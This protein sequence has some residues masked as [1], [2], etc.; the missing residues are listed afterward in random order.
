MME[1][2]IELINGNYYDVTYDENEVAIL[3]VLIGNH[4]D[5]LSQV[6]LRLKSDERILKVKSDYVPENNELKSE[7]NQLR[8]KIKDLYELNEHLIK[9]RNVIF[10]SIKKTSKLWLDIDKN[11]VKILD[12]YLLDL[13]NIIKASKNLTDNEYLKRFP[14][15]EKDKYR[16]FMSKEDEERNNEENDKLLREIQ[17]KN[18]ILFGKSKLIIK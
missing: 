12:E 6:N 13:K 8:S 10:K 9:C 5:M 4:D 16:M 1:N 2:K 18:K 11:T 7:L 14:E 17:A 3:M 15:L